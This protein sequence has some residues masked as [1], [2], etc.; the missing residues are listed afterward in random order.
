MISGAGHD[1]M[2]VARRLPAAMLF[3]RSPGGLSH[4]PDE[5]V[6][7]ADVEAAVAAGVEFLRSLR[8]NRPMLDQLSASKLRPKRE[9]SHA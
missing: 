9:A 1:A 8:E 4:H 2:I 3:L 6:I 5:A 7:P